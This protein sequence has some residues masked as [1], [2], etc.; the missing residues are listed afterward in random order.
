MRPNLRISLSVHGL[1]RT[2]RLARFLKFLYCVVR[3]LLLLGLLFLRT[4][5]YM[6]IDDYHQDEGQYTNSSTSTTSMCCYILPFWLSATFPSLCR[7]NMKA[8]I[9]IASQ[10]LNPLKSRKALPPNSNIGA[11]IITS[12]ILGVFFTIIVCIGPPNHI[13]I[14]KAPTLNLDLRS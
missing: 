1:C 2:T 11:Q 4:F 10:P 12:T 5:A 8:E 3:L 9:Q 13:P 14:I 6:R 7:C